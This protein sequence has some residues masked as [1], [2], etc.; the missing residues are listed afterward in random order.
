MPSEEVILPFPTSGALGEATQVRSTL[1]AS[2]IASLRRHDLFDRYVALLSPAHREAVLS[3]VA[4]QWLPIAVGRAHYH[5]CDQLGLTP[6][7]QVQIGGEVSIKI[8]DTFLGV[9]IRT[10]KQAGVTPWILLSRGHQMYSRIFE[11]GGGIRV[12]RY[13][14][15]EARAD[16]VGI[17]LLTIPYF[18][19]GLRGIYQGAISLFCVQAY[20]QEM[21]RE[22]GPTRAS[23]RLSWV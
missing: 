9:V 16:I 17:P 12:I 3:S 5:A 20:V 8:H 18:R 4:G 2:S 11:G 22:A 21:S 6:A 15:K 14:P 19:N 23:L 1:L 10:A 13:G 7:Q